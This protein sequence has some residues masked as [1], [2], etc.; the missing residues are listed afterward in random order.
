MAEP[1]SVVLVAVGGYG[2]NYVNALLSRPE[3]GAPRIVGVVDPFAERCRRIDDMRQASIPIYERPSDFYAEH[4]A[5]LCVISSP[6]H[7]H[8][9]HTCAALEHGSSVL[10][11]KPLGA[12]IQEAGRMI[13][14]RDRCAGFVA[15]G[16]QWSFSS[17]I[18]LLK[19]DVLSG[20]LG[21]PQRL[22]TLVL[23]PRN[24]T[25]YRRNDWAGAQK[26]RAGD[27]ILDS[28]AN[29]AAAHYLHNMFYVIGPAIDRSDMPVEVTAELYR[30]NSIGNYDTGVMR[31][32]TQSG[33]ELLFYASHAVDTT[34]GPEFIFEFEHATVRLARRG[35]PIRAE[36]SDGSTREYGNPDAD[37]MLKLRECLAAVRGECDVVCGPEAAAAQTLCMNGMQESAEISEF[38]VEMISR[39][40]EEGRKE[41]VAE[42]LGDILAGA[43]ESGCLP[44]EKGI[45]WAVGGRTVDLRKYDAFPGA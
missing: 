15:I 31:A 9:T 28:P 44:A 8:C 20:R 3:P 22:R 6:I 14:T 23:W 25:Y 5:R 24:E 13:E 32:R 27:W 2:N 37:N 35:E 4:D 16:Y 17:A 36:F 19:A 10:C 42:G 39:R 40:G 12:R 33:A 45:P 29:N 38:P 21:R 11:E 43:Y 41:T 7:L 1:I 26:T 30:A 18:Q 34:R